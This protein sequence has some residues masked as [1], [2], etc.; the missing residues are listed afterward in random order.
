M[1]D[2]VERRVRG[3]RGTRYYL[4]KWKG[5]EDEHNEWIQEDDLTCGALVYEYN[6]KKKQQNRQQALLHETDEIQS[7]N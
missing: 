2:K 4:I 6:Q 5:Y 7:L 1:D 3:S